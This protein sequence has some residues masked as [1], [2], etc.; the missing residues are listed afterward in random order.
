M[1]LHNRRIPKVRVGVGVCPMES[2]YNQTRKMTLNH[3]V[4]MLFMQDQQIADLRTLIKKYRKLEA[5]IA[6]QSQGP[7]GE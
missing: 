5:V 2:S 1:K 4:C 3:C 6:V 7:K